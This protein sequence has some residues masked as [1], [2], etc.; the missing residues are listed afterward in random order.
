MTGQQTM[1]K[2]KIS[3]VVAVG[4]DH[5][6]NLVIGKDSQLLWRIKD[7]LRRFKELTIGHPIIMGRK[8]FLSIVEALGKPLPGRTNIVVTRD[9]NFKHEGVLV[10][11]SLEAAIMEAF[12]LDQDEIFIGGGGEIYK[13]ALPLAD[14]LYLTLIDNVKE[15]NVFFP[16]YEE[17]FTK[18]TFEE[19]RTDEET[20]LRYSWINFERES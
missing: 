4:H 6:G 20:G 11:H 17:I 7:D 16:S 1:T 2:A 15:G 13:E 14:K 10:A 5:G 8:T 12:S 19:V 3:I 18:K 9:M